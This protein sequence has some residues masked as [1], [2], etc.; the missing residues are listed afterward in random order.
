M[1]LKLLLLVIAVL[2]VAPAFAADDMDTFTRRLAAEKDRGEEVEIYMMMG[3]Y[4]A[5]RHVY[6][7]AAE[8]YAKALPDL[9]NRVTDD[10]MT[11]VAAY[12]SWGGKLKAAE[13]ELHTLLQKNPANVRARTQLSQVLLWSNDLNRAFSEAETCL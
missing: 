4:H 5:K 8:A 12:L 6:E 9:R 13:T 1:K 3:D 11:Q 7:K 2:L 10:E